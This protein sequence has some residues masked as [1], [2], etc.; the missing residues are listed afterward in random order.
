MLEYKSAWD[1]AAARQASEAP[2]LEEGSDGVRIMT[3]HRAQG[4]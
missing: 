4:S 3:V 1:E 2:I